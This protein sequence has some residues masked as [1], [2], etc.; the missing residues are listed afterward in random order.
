MN[1]SNYTSDQVTIN[2]YSAISVN[3][4]YG[5]NTSGKYVQV[6]NRS[7]LPICVLH[8]SG[9]IDEIQPKLNPITDMPED[10]QNLIE[11][12]VCHFNEDFRLKT[13][14]SNVKSSNQSKNNNN[15]STDNCNAVSYKISADIFRAGN[16]KRVDEAGIVIAA[17]INK[18]KLLARRRCS[19]NILD[20]FF[21]EFRNRHFGNRTE[22][23][24]NSTPFAIVANTHSIDIDNL[25]VGIDGL[26]GHVSVKHDLDSVEYLRLLVRTDDGNVHEQNISGWKWGTT[27]IKE[28]SVRGCS[29]I[30]GTTR[31][32]VTTACHDRKMEAKSRISESEVNERIKEATARRDATIEELEAEIARLR[33]KMKTL[34]EDLK[35]AE[36]RV[37]AAESATDSTIKQQTAYA[38]FFQQ[39]MK[40]EQEMHAYAEERK[41]EKRKHKWEKARTK[42]ER[43]SAKLEK[44]FKK[45]REE[46]ELRMQKEKRKWDKKREKATADNAYKKA[47][48]D[49]DKTIAELKRKDRAEQMDL[50]KT[51]VTVLGAAIS[52]GSIFLSSR[53]S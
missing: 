29:I 17:Y 22:E 40:N 26:T 21:D 4:V 30:L 15:P 13:S 27:D 23:L 39:S 5:E 49:Y 43:Q 46:F 28:L 32:A 50:I 51:G 12:V 25:Y 31:E 6:I 2:R 36:S 7:S 16:V 35:D 42:L 11:I 20:T 9:V 3:F 1:S 8:G 45:R 37:K 10:D 18:D 24:Y 19:S 52:L 34:E 44:K 14:A 47:K 53:K 33:R 48:L 41:R 38:N